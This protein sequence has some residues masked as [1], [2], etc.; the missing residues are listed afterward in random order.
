[1]IDRNHSGITFEQLG[2]AQR[3]G[4][5]TART[6]PRVARGLRVL[7][8]GACA[9]ALVLGARAPA[10]VAQS[11]GSNGTLVFTRGIAGNF[12]D[13][14]A[15][16]PPPG[17]GQLKITNNIPTSG[18]IPVNVAIGAEAADPAF[19]PDGSLM[20]WMEST[21][22]VRQLVVARFAPL[23]QRA[24]GG[25]VTGFTPILTGGFAH[26]SWSRDNVIAVDNGRGI[27]VVRAD[28]T[29]FAQIRSTG[30]HPSWSPDGRRIAFADDSGGSSPRHPDGTSAIYVM[31]ADGSNVQKLSNIEDTLAEFV[32]APDWS[33]DGTRIAFF[34]SAK[35]FVIG[36]DGTGVHVVAP[37]GTEPKW[38]PDGKKIAW[39][40]GGVVSAAPGTIHII[41]DDGTNETSFTPAFSLCSDI[42][43]PGNFSQCD[44]YPLGRLAWQPR[45]SAGG[46]AA[47]AT[48]LSS[49]PN[50]SVF[51][52]GVTFTATVSPV[53]PGAGAPSGTVSFFD[54]TA[55]LGTR[56]LSGGQATL[57][58]A[59][60][61]VGLHT[62]TAVYGGDANFS[63]STSGALTQTVNRASTPTSL[64]SGPSVSVF[65]QGLTFTATVGAVAPGAGTPSGTVSFFDGTAVLGTRTLSGGQATLASASLAVGVH[66]ITAVFGGD[67]NFSGSTSGALIQTV[68]KASTTTSLSA[69]RCGI[70]LTATVSPVAPGAGTPSGTVSFFDGTTGIGTRTLSGGQATLA[71]ASLAVGL[72]TITAVYGGDANFTG[73]TSGAVTHTTATPPAP[74]PGAY[75]ITDLGTLPPAVDPLTGLTNPTFTLS[76]AAAINCVGEVVGIS[77]QAPG[78]FS[79]TVITR[80]F[81]WTAAGGM[82]DLGRFGGSCQSLA[83]GINESG[84]VTG[85]SRSP[86]AECGLNGP[87]PDHAWVVDGG[88][89]DIGKLPSLHCGDDTRANGVNS[90]GQVVGSSGRRAFL[91]QKS[92]GMSDLGQDCFPV[93]INDSGQIVGF[94]LAA[95]GP[96]VLDLQTRAVTVLDNPGDP[97]SSVPV[98]I[99]AGGQVVG[100]AEFNSVTRA[101]LWA[102]GRATIIGGD[103]SFAE[104]INSAGQVVGSNGPRAFIYSGGVLRDLDALLPAG[105]GWVL[106]GANGI[107]D[108]GQIVGG[109]THNGKLRAFLMTRSKLQLV[110]LEVNQAIQNWRNAVPLTEGKATYV[111]AF[112]QWPDPGTKNVTLLLDGTRD[113]ALLPGSPLRPVNGPLAVDND[114]FSKRNTFAGSLNWRLPPEWTHGNVSL[115]VRTDPDIK[116]LP[117]LGCQEEAGSTP[118]DCA[119]DVSFEPVGK[120]DIRFFGISWK[121]TT[122]GTTYL[123]PGLMAAQD[124]AQR[125]KAILPSARVSWDFVAV[126]KVFQAAVTNPNGTFNNPGVFKLEDDI[127]S[128]LLDLRSQDDCQASCHRIYLG[129]FNDPPAGS[130]GGKASGIP[131]TVAVASYRS[132][133]N[134]F[135]VAHELGHDLGREHTVSSSLG[136]VTD[137]AGNPI[138]KQG[139]CGES[140]ALTDPDWLDT[141]TTGGNTFAAI[142][143]MSAGDQQL[144][145]GLDTVTADTTGAVGGVI[146][147]TQHFE[148]MSYCQPSASQWNWISFRTYLAARDQ[149]NTLFKPTDFTSGLPVDP[150]LLLVRG[151]IDTRSGSLTFLPFA[152]VA[153][154]SS[155]D[156]PPPGPYVLEARGANG[157]LL[158]T[159]PFDAKPS[160]VDI[161]FAPLGTVANFLVAVPDSGIAS[162]DIVRGATRLGSIAA[163][164]HAP[165]VRVL[166]PAGG[167]TFGGSSFSVRWS[168]SDADGDALSYSLQYSA[169]NGSTW[170]TLATDLTGTALTVDA[171]G[172]PGSARGVV[173]VIASDG[174]NS[175]AAVSGAFTVANHAPLLTPLSPLRDAQFTKQQSIVLAADAFDVQDGPL[176][177]R[178]FR[179]TV[180]GNVVGAGDTV[181]LS[182][183]Q[184]SDG[185]HR[186]GITVT[187]SAGLSTTREIAFSIGSISL[188]GFDSTPPVTTASMR[189]GPNANGWTSSDVRIDLHATDE[190]GGSGVKDI[191]YT[192]TNGTTSATRVVSGD[193]AAVLV[194]LEG[195]NSLDY[196][197]TDNA[198][199]AE[200]VH[201]LVVRIDRTPPTITGSRSPAPNANGWNNT[202][203]TVSFSCSDALSGIASCPGPT[204]L[205]AEGANQSVTG[206][207]LDLAD[208][209]GSA[210]VSA[211]NIDKTTPVTTATQMPPPNANGWNRTPVSVT[212]TA[213]DNLSGVARTEFNLDGAGW[214]PYA[215]TI[216]ITGEGIHAL[217]YRSRDRADNLESARMLTVQIDLTPPEAVLQ[218]DPAAQDLKVVGR[219]LLSGVLDPT[220]ATTAATPA[221]EGRRE[222]RTYRIQ[223]RADNT[224]VLVVDVKR[225]GHELK[226]SV[227]STSYN[228]A[229]PVAAP[230]NRLAFEWSLAAGATLKELEQ[231][232]EVGA[233]ETRREVQAKFEA[234]KNETTIEI[235][236][237]GR[238]R[239]IKRPGLVLLRL[240]TDQG[241][242]LIEFD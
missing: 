195:T 13:I 8:A 95:D 165:S 40:I 201:H 186:A 110:A 60:L 132:P 74:L 24:T 15:Q 167:E 10:A 78:G 209:P 14:Y 190:A 159:I 53:A 147:P 94:G 71:T 118:H 12:S 145:F 242:L 67:G 72:H 20:A 208:N 141:Y 34:G 173:R 29:G 56:A 181:V 236:T 193:S 51:G 103:N 203:V 21:V 220:S 238:E 43:P 125:L 172:L 79:C 32:E 52:Q 70:T 106:G 68:N 138:L 228:G 188:P 112:L 227:V 35:I 231:E 160:H 19:S 163:S 37:L 65:G 221:G 3:A 200:T 111:R 199:N 142:G 117:D 77:Q 83:T 81:R 84:L 107:N 6:G 114:P 42:V 153:S 101:V 150:T 168:G 144:I 85:F 115:S 218:F 122:T 157:A 146:D 1:M 58:S 129:L 98:A 235:E 223:D 91:W 156:L 133:F 25:P 69:G 158:A 161:P 213:S 27:S 185:A 175:T 123:A 124:E 180:D 140:A 113:G 143:P 82:Q 126:P 50:P 66:T 96:C 191:H 86:F 226:A 217:R 41:N 182:A 55:V 54:G 30:A 18:R 169:D 149:L 47:T 28:G 237:R 222:R 49:V 229:A 76:A 104:G 192:L 178:S 240:A 187:D 116:D 230:E 22:G 234:K 166:A 121:D 48:S 93:A 189:P 214:G 134:R 9:L 207:A 239:S 39:L 170:R 63:G 210:T 131:G 2:P 16:D 26:P 139:W 92:T 197:A 215:G 204:T 109:G 128:T 62:I 135:V 31:N 105:S 5:D 119:A 177:G 46:S 108:A 64:S 174:F 151:Q 61:A 33:P 75:T 196:F 100:F 171:S 73:S 212:L 7:A 136:F 155:P 224:L 23:P 130:L 233:E 219:D 11:P 59:S 202:D 120:L 44:V 90:L 152:R 232:I 137:S 154:A 184:L 198:N 205:S 99:N 88:L 183:G 17:G 45:P 148:L 179:W 176:G 241:R 211:I 80:P 206:T 36:A 57:A 127:N 225:E 97:F 89:N 164:A 38:S 102:N 194:A 162:V 87:M 216:A 4:I